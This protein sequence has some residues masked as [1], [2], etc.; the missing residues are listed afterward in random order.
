MSELGSDFS[1]NHG[2][3]GDDMTLTKLILH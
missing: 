1:G 2:M 3:L